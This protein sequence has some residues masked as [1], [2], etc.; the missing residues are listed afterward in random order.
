MTNV[1]RFAWGAAGSLADEVVSLWDAVRSDATLKL[2]PRYRSG[3][4]WL[5]RVLLAGVG[6][7]L[8]VAYQSDQPAI[9]MGVGAA[10]PTILRY[11]A[12]QR[13]Q[14]PPSSA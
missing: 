5:V 10:A 9:C 1:E 14:L 11:L 8:A 12:S 13:P 2:A 4:Y 7:A 3:V 6:G